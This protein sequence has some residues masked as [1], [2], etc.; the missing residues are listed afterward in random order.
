MRRLYM[1]FEQL[2]EVLPQRVLDIMDQ[3]QEGKFDV[4]VDHRRLGPSVNRLVLGML[5]SSLF[6]GSALMLCYDVPPLIFTGEK[7]Y[8]AGLHDVS[9][10]G[11]LG[12][13]TSL[14]V[15]LRLMW[16]IAK[17]GHLDHKE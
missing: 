6:V 2:A 4:H 16:A 12:C 3:V 8:F 14:F 17:S 9:I 5:T 13:I 11:L 7:P 10:L 15:G 1:G